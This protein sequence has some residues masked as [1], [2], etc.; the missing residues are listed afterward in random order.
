MLLIQDSCSR[1]LLQTKDEGG[2]TTNLTIFGWLQSNCSGDISIGSCINSSITSCEGKS[3]SSIAFFLTCNSALIAKRFSLEE[4]LHDENVQIQLECSM[5]IINRLT[6][7]CS[8]HSQRSFY[9][10]YIHS[11]CGSGLVHCDHNSHKPSYHWLSIQ[12]QCISCYFCATTG[13]YRKKQSIYSYQVHK[14][15]FK[16]N[17]SSQFDLLIQNFMFRINGEQFVNSIA[18]NAADTLGTVIAAAQQCHHN[19]F[20]SSEINGLLHEIQVININRSANAAG[21]ALHR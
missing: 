1:D 7:K 6:S 16:R 3:S 8:H 11:W 12:V 13:S 18:A 9:I 17:Y 15:I 14:W 2:L 10:D 19:D 21:C 5:I 4:I 20:V